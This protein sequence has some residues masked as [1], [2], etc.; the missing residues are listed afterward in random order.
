MAGFGLGL[1][2]LNRFTHELL[3]RA[4]WGKERAD[5][6][7]WRVAHLRLKPIRDPLGAFGI[8]HRR[9]IPMI[10]ACSTLSCGTLQ[11]RPNDAPHSAEIGGF[12]FVPAAEESGE[13]VD[14]RVVAFIARAAADS[15]PVVYIGQ[16][17]M[18][19]EPRW[20]C[21]LAAEVC[22]RAGVRAVIIAGWSGIDAAAVADNS[23]LLVAAD[24]PHDWLFPRCACVVHHCSIGTMAAALRAGV[25]QVPTPFAVDQPYNAAMLVRI[26]VAP[27]AVPWGVV[28]GAVLAAEVARAIDPTKPFA[29]AARR[30]S[31][32][33]RAESAGA[34]DRYANMVEAAQRWA[35]V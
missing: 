1:R 22:A 21:G 29:A 25:P 3:L 11:A 19:A 10:V 28:S 16:G 4:A 9:G 27:A 13:T 17:S 23:A 26:G 32:F 5:V 15:I 31:A 14:Q 8:I 20:L 24:V 34:L 6:N 33:V 2:C 7:A 35:E 30:V 18:A 12:V